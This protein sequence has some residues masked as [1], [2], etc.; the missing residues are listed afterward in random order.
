VH[1]WSI[2]CVITT[3]TEFNYTTAIITS[4]PDETFEVG[5]TVSVG[6]IKYQKINV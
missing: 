1:I 2:K 4:I 6:N 5:N 3:P